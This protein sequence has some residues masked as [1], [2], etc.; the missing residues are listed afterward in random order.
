MKLR[1]EMDNPGYR[2]RPDMFVDVN[3]P[4]AI[5]D[6]LTVPADAVLDTGTR[7]IVFAE[8]S[9]GVYEPRQV[10][11]GWR[12]GEFAQV[13]HGLSEGDRIVVSGT[14][15]VSSETR[16]KA[17]A[18][19]AASAT[20]TIDPVCGMEVDPAKARAADRVLEHDHRTYY[21]CADECKKQFA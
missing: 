1:L 4:V 7:T 18:V 2:F 6:A 21:F 11:T 10:Q 12:F 15:L 20:A 19:A 17:A 5:P 14:F 8:R 16:M 3:I 13:T 9:P